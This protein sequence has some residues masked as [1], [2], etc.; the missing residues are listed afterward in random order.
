ME[1][2]A[3]KFSRKRKRQRGNRKLVVN[4][5]VE[6]R[7]KEDG[8]N[9]S[10]HPGEVIKCGK[11]SRH[12]RY[13]NILMDNG[14]DK[15][16][17]KVT[18]SAVLDGSSCSKEKRSNKRGYIRPFPPPVEFGKLDLPYGLCVDVNYQEAWWEGV[19][20]DRDN[21][22][23]ERNIFF[24][25]LGD[26]LKIGIDCLRITQD[27]DE[28]TENWQRR[29]NWVLFE[30]VEKYA[31]GP[32]C[33]ASVKQMWYDVRGIKGFEYIRDWVFNKKDSWKE[34]VLEALGNFFYFTQKEA[35][36][37]NYAEP[38]PYVDMST[39][40]DMS[41]PEA[42]ATY[43][44]QPN[45]DT[46][47]DGAFIKNH[48]NDSDVRAI[49]NPLKTGDLAARSLDTVSEFVSTPP[50]QEESSID[51]LEDAAADMCIVNESE[52][53]C[54][55]KEEL[56]QKEL[57]TPIQEG[58]LGSTYN[59]DNEKPKR[60]ARRRT[61]IWKSVKLPGAKP[62]ED[63]IVKYALAR[64]SKRLSYPLLMKVRKHILYLG[65][66]IEKFKD[67]YMY[68]S[69]DGKCYN[70]LL[71]L[72]QEMKED[73][74]MRNSLTSQ[75]DVISLHTSSDIKCTNLPDEQQENSQSS[76]FCQ[77]ITPPSSDQV[78]IEPEYCP[79]AVLEYCLSG[80]DRACD[81]HASN[82]MTLK[83]TKHL[84]AAGWK[85]FWYCT[86]SEKRLLQ[87][88]SP[89]NTYCSLRAACEG[90]LE[91][92]LSQL[93]TSDMRP[94]ETECSNEED[95][96]LIDGDKLS[97]KL[98]KG[99]FSKSSGK[100]SIISQSRKF[101]RLDKG[102]VKGN[103]KIQ[104]KKKE[105]LLKII[106]ELLERDPEFNAIEYATESVLINN[107]KLRHKENTELRQ[108]K[109]DRSR[110]SRALTSIKEDNESSHHMRVTRS[111]KRV[112]Q[113]CPFSPQ[114][115]L[116][117]FSWLIGNNIVLPRA[118]VY[119]KSRGSTFPLAEG[120][121][122]CQGIKC[123]CC[124]KVWSCGS[125]E[126]HAVG[127]SN[128]RPAARIFLED[129]RSIFDCQIQIMHNRI[130]RGFLKKPS[131]MVNGN[132]SQGENDSICS[133]CHNGG[134]LI[135][136]DQC[137]SSFHLGCL[138]LECLHK[139]HAKCQ[140]KR[141]ARKLKKYQEWFC[142][143]GCEKIWLSLHKLLGMATPVGENNLTWTLMKC[144]KY[145]SCNCDDPD[146][147]YLTESHSKLNIA[148]AV[149]HECFE[150]LQDPYSSTDLVEDVIFS[151]WS[152]LNRLNFEGF[153]TVLLERDDEIICVATIRVYGEKVAEV[154][155]VAT[156]SQYRQQ[157]MC[158]IL[159]DELEKKLKELGVER[160][161]LPAVPDVFD[162]W[163]GAF[164]FSPMRKSERLQYLDCNFLDFPDTIMCHKLL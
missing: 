144:I 117:V 70:S 19:I 104:S 122:T 30:L 6:V 7:S 64:N 48:V 76:D 98:S 28:F 88:C 131:D 34:L 128:G 14:K 50:V 73:I 65:W 155:L 114:K 63:A 129:G 151:R 43:V 13:E 143:K 25:D 92:R 134:E 87:Y 20:C 146:I 115:P 45:I 110:L 124:K 69:P 39:N 61:R 62:C 84:S 80:T 38:T 72:C 137:P 54:S 83:A 53:F 101:L 135:L 154:P 108:P 1:P 119:Y 113:V 57:L 116:N 36:E 90:Y 40:L 85:M 32:C 18:V 150:P 125:F 17:D 142:S 141:G 15:L 164:N 33:L 52:E 56:V 112:E 74:L 29:G 147:D 158:R 120:Q 100:S 58:N 46:S 163:T 59:G 97:S 31:P 111:R 159:M 127:R 136:C 156:R 47:T 91:E 126:D 8:L 107:A 60:S 148:L 162:T 27:W 132:M 106:Y 21:G 68:Y 94:T 4:D 11:Q 82:I 118:K 71:K 5:K 152:E 10:W 55:H 160:L 102:R 2:Q 81:D 24:P 133:V 49:D 75:A 130:M 95:E 41:N 3:P 153:Y 89:Q 51:P 78:L 99:M 12:V 35:L 140:T 139:Y 105:N 103:E 96:G 42:V 67:I 157:G 22:R 79:Q 161:V 145:E 66:K 138:G 26:Q 121:I 109:T 37:L 9:G 123:T 23:E 16:V 93:A 149:M 77:Q 44:N 86:M